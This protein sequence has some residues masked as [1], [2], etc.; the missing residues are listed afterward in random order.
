MWDLDFKIQFDTSEDE[1][2]LRVPLATFAANYEQEGGVCV[3]FVEYLDTYFDNSKSILIG[4]LFFQSIY[5]QYTLT[6]PYGV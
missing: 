2:Y 4:G 1:N 6:S 5:A 3:I